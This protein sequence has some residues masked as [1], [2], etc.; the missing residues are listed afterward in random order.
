[1]L[2][3]E[4][5]KYQTTPTDDNKM[6]WNEAKANFEICQENLPLLIQDHTDLKFQKF[7]NKGGKLLSY[8][9][10][11]AYTLIAIVKMKTEQGKKGT[12][13]K[14]INAI[15]SRYYETLYN[16]PIGGKEE[17]ASFL[18]TITLDKVTDEQKRLLNAPIT[19]KE[20]ETIIKGLTTNKSPGPDGYGA[21]F[22]KVMIFTISPTLN[23]LYIHMIDNHTYFPTGSLAHIRVLPKGHRTSNFI[24]S[25]IP[26]KH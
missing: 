2:K 25:N 3:Q 14:D 8:L 13:P 24:P 19:K 15:F 11:E 12:V 6:K 22:Y 10:K 9:T 1:M 21:E 20:V 16:K 17:M 26:N 18:D 7:G 4:Y 23:S 5:Q